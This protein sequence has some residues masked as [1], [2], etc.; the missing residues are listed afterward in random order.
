[1]RRCSACLANSPKAGRTWHRP[2]IPR[3]PHTESRSTPKRRAASSTVVPGGHAAPPAGR[4]EDGDGHRSS[5]RSGHVGGAL[6]DPNPRRRSASAGD[7]A[8]RR[9]RAGRPR[10]RAASSGSPSM[11]NERRRHSATCSCAVF[12]P[13]ISR[14]A[15]DRTLEP[16]GE[17]HLVALVA[18]A[19]VDLGGDVP[20]RDHHD[21]GP[22]AGHGAPPPRARPASRDTTVSWHALG[23]VEWVAAT[24]PAPEHV[25]ERPIPMSRG[26]RRTGYR[27]ARSMQ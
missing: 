25:R 4:H 1:M 10:L 24:P 26:R 8:G 6:P 18:G 27:A 3:P 9:R 13:A 19:G 17:E 23:K 2:Q 22:V 11:G 16:G 5:R 12:L 21:L 14:G 7:R 20:P 15:L